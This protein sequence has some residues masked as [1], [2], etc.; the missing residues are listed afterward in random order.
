MTQSRS[1]LTHLDADRRGVG[2]DDRGE[3]KPTRL[4]FALG[5]LL[6]G[7]QFGVVDGD[8]TPAPAQAMGFAGY[9]TAPAAPVT[10]E[11]Y[12]K[13]TG[14]WDVIATT[15]SSTSVSF[16]AGIWGGNPN[17]YQW[18][19]S[20]AIDDASGSECRFSESCELSLTYG[21]DTA[22]VR[23][24]VGYGDAL[25]FTPG[26]QDCMSEAIDD[27]STFTDA[28]LECQ[29][30][31]ADAT[32]VHYRRAWWRS[33]FYTSL[34]D[35]SLAEY[36]GRVYMATVLADGS[37]EVARTV[38]SFGLLSAP[39]SFDGG[40][41]SFDPQTPPQL[42]VAQGGYLYLFARGSDDN[43]W[44]RRLQG[45][46]WTDWQALTTDGSVQGDIAAAV[47]E[48]EVLP[49]MHVAWNDGTG[50]EYRQISGGVE[51]AAYHFD[52]ALEARLASDGVEHVGLVLREDALLTTH[53]VSQSAGWVPSS[54]SWRGSAAIP[55][56]SN[57][58]WA[59]GAF[60]FAYA[61][62]H[63]ADDVG[64]YVE[65]QVVY[66]RIPLAGPPGPV[67]QIGYWE[68]DATADPRV[69]LAVHRGRLVAAWNDGRP[70][71]QQAR[72]DAASPSQPWIAGRA[73]AEYVATTGRPVIGAANLRSGPPQEYGSD[74]RGDDVY[75]TSR[76]HPSEG[77]G[78]RQVFGNLSRETMRFE[79]DAQFDL[80]DFPAMSGC[81]NKNGA[82]PATW[83]DNLYE[84]DRPIISEIG[85]MQWLVPDWLGSH[86][87][88]DVGRWGCEEGI[89]A[90]VEPYGRSCRLAKL[91]VL[92]KP[93]GGAYTCGGAYF[94][95][96][97]SA[98]TVWNEVGH[99][100][101]DGLG[102]KDD[103]SLPNPVEADAIRSGLP[104]GVLEEADA[105]FRESLGG[106][107]DTDRCPG[108]IATYDA[109]SAQHSM[110]YAWWWYATNGDVM[111]ELI[112]ED[113]D[114]GNDLLQRKY[115][116]LRTNIY[117]GVEFDDEGFPLE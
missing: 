37:I 21:V 86:I 68:A 64:G 52:G 9:T 12:D 74:N 82:P 88:G 13:S 107:G 97:S 24:R 11:A 25:D 76:L 106:C 80:H 104:L 59:G 85:A 113:L 95:Q 69:G 89:W 98:W 43:L 103:A 112:E 63:T 32:R 14:T 62:E 33:P 90:D 67:G 57:L 22:R 16:P 117:G 35:P 100:T 111:R 10:I 61:R 70:G 78:T 19:V 51:L 2:P 23:T 36:V 56:V 3:M 44:T 77:V 92:I 87:F 73:F 109:T 79:L 42:A 39:W 116:W 54:P 101:A 102:I 30:P 28:A 53:L 105:L 17:L 71:V 66:S 114:D 27:G 31:A 47:T 26:W 45:N 94:P 75:I 18:S 91:P 81:P 15:V 4:L 1:D 110:I 49:R 20:A 96:N 46:A 41:G 34:A 60:H 93:N 55:D 48:G 8:H 65:H 29:N 115:D 50:I 5:L 7:C 99:Y 84:E 58:V 40:P 83:I 6:G 108:F 38:D 72:M